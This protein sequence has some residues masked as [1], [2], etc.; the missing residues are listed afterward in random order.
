[1]DFLSG[2]EKARTMRAGC[3]FW[4]VAELKARLY[5]P[6][7]REDEMAD[8][9]INIVEGK[10]DPIGDVPPAQL[11]GLEAFV[12]EVNRYAGLEPSVESISEIR[13]GLSD[14]ALKMLRSVVVDD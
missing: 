3:R 5:L 2:I 12:R 4:A 1:L 8:S 6:A 7:I 11:R 13:A 10:R 9:V 14:A